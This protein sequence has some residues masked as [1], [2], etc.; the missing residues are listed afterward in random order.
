MI[1]TPSISAAKF[2]PGDLGLISNWALVY[3][4]TIVKGKNCGIQAF[5]VQ[6]RDEN[7]NVLPGI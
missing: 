5:F 7:Q 1:N 6:I 3:A 2:W 4:Q